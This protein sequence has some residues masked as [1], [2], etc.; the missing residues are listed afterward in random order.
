MPNKPTV[1]ISYSHADKR[2]LG[3]MKQ[4][5]KFLRDQIDLW[6]DTQ[7]RPGQIWREEIQQ[8]LERADIAILLISADFFN[9]DY[10]ELN[11]LPPLLKA[12][13]QRGTKILS[14]IVRPCLFKEYK[15]IAKYQAI[16]DPKAPLSTLTEAQQE[17]AFMELARVVKSTISTQK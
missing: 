4:H 5:F 15:E 12:A 14:L 1:F 9:S 17:M 11:E 2:W 6:D 16:N 3:A 13:D 10:I 7:I 8:A